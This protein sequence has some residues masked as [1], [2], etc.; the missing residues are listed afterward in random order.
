M[1]AQCS[2]LQGTVT[3]EK[4]ITYASRF[5]N[6]RAVKGE[7]F[8]LCSNNIVKQKHTSISVFPTISRAR[9]Y[10][11]TIMRFIKSHKKFKDGLPDVM[12]DVNEIHSQ[13][14]IITRYLLFCALHKSFPVNNSF[15]YI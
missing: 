2:F 6:H 3:N 8:A 5:K 9:P 4:I 10:L 12:H 14:K 15:V 11:D 7:V 1:N 13:L